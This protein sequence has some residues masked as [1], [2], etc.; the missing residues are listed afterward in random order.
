MHSLDP[1]SV[2]LT[3]IQIKTAAAGATTSSPPTTRAASPPATKAS[4]VQAASPAVVPN[5]AS[6]GS[7]DEHNATLE[8]AKAFNK[9]YTS[10]GPPVSPYKPPTKPKVDLFAE[11]GRKVEEFDFGDPYTSKE[12]DKACLVSSMIP[13]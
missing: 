2:V 13:I 11:D 6:S 3:T 7:G 5:G 1:H 8:D 10:T 12:D 4:P 9:P